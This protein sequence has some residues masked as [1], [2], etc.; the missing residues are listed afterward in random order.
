MSI[1]I[2]RDRDWKMFGVDG[3]EY[4]KC[5]VDT[6]H[7]Y[8]HVLNDYWGSEARGWRVF[9]CKSIVTADELNA[10]RNEDSAYWIEDLR[11][12]PTGRRTGAGRV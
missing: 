3:N 12:R 1:A 8:A 5:E 2:Y 10:Y 4:E 11:P 6:S 9:S 7:T